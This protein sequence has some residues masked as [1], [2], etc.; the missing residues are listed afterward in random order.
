MS[1]ARPDIVVPQEA[2]ERGLII[3]GELRSETA[4]I[5]SMLAQFS[6]I[7]PGSRE[8]EIY[9]YPTVD[10]A[11]KLFAAP[12]PF[13]FEGEVTARD[14]VEEQ[15]KAAGI[16]TKPGSQITYKEAM[17]WTASS[18]SIEN[19][20][21]NT[22]SQDR[23]SKDFHSS[24]WFVMNRC[25]L[26]QVLANPEKEDL[27]AAKQHGF[28]ERT[29]SLA[30]LDGAT[31]EI[32]RRIQSH[33]LGVAREEKKTGYSLCVRDFNDEERVKSDVEAL[34]ILASFASR[35]RTMLS[36]WSTE[37]VAGNHHRHWLFNIPKFPK[38]QE[39]IEP[40]VPRDHAQCAKFLTGAFRVYCGAKHRELFDA[41][42]YAQL[43]H[44]LPL[45]VEIVRLFS[46]IQSALVFALQEPKTAKRPQIRALYEKFMKKY[47]PDFSDLWPL[48]SKL[49]G[50]SLSDI[51]NAVVHGEV[52]VESDWTALSYAGQNLRWMLERILLISLGWD[53]H[54]SDVSPQRLRLFYAH[55]WHTEQ[56]KIQA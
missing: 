26:L 40:L 11:R 23:S 37:R 20:H 22:T 55:Q 35:E 4:R 16:W 46:G 5:P 29:F 32:R 51:R 12:P 1:E 30:L 9:F 10:Q 48:L 53:V 31:A 13:S 34:L 50:A 42:V 38:R 54:T 49:S 2:A 17:Y 52:F 25:F 8:A 41:A 18:G 24:A 28:P 21:I 19:L 7:D 44:D 14:G 39:R 6:K 3:S 36:H 27:E 56:K 47:S 33:K 15:W 43:S 45:E